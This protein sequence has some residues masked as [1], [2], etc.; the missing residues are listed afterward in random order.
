M[1]FMSLWESI[2]SPFTKTWMLIINSGT[3]LIQCFLWNNI[4]SFT[5]AHFIC[6]C[7]IFYYMYIWIIISWTR[8]IIYTNILRSSSYWNC[9]S[10]ISKFL[11]RIILSR[12]WLVK[13]LLRNNILSH[14][15][16]HFMRDYSIFNSIWICLVRSWTRNIRLNFIIWSTSNYYLLCI[17][18]KLLLIGV[19]P[20][21]WLI[22]H[23]LLN[24]VSSL[25]FRHCNWFCFFFC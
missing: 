18:S 17:F 16:W 14:A 11:W 8:A 15:F 1:F 24:N 4:C 25:W 19:L 10:I 7:S 9:L 2:R 6:N 12:S 23:M 20:W 5:V 22:F 13:H 3:W 21:P